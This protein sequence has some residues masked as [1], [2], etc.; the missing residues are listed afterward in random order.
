MNH[1]KLSSKKEMKPSKTKHRTLDV[2]TD[3]EL[4]GIIC[5]LQGEVAALQKSYN[6]LFDEYRVTKD[7]STKTGLKRR[8]ADAMSAVHQ[9]VGIALQH[10]R[11]AC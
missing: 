1:A 8:M 9:R 10:S 2:D 11:E 6:D 5:S 4:D 3:N 7:V